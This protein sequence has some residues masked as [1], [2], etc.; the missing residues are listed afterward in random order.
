MIELA[1][2]RVESLKRLGLWR[3]REPEKDCARCGETIPPRRARHPRVKYCS[4]ECQRQPSRDRQ[5]LHRQRQRDGEPSVRERRAERDRQILAMR[6][7]GQTIVGIA[8]HMNLHKDTIS[9]VCRR[10]W[11]R[12][13]YRSIRLVARTVEITLWRMAAERKGVAVGDVL[14]EAA[15]DISERVVRGIR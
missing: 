5:A 9:N 12:S 15:N 14:R 1:K 8:K 7:D 13:E 3:E 6:A 2:E 11:P 4:N 10:R